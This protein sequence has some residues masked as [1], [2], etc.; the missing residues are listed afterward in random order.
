MLIVLMNVALLLQFKFA[1]NPTTRQLAQEGYEARLEINVGLLDKALD[2]RRRIA[3]LLGYKTWADYVTEPKMIKTG[4]GVQDVRSLPWLHWR[5]VTEVSLHSS[6][7]TSKLSS[8][9]L[10]RRS[11]ISSSRSR[12]KNTWR[13]VSPSTAN[14]TS[15]TTATTTAST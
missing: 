11:A 9:L 1:E 10:V 3:S 12:R 13:R 5:D 8:D 14:S 6:S 7:T 15:G 4:K 2:L